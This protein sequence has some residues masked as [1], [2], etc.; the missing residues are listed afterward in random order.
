[1]DAGSEEGGV[2]VVGAILTAATR[3][4]LLFQSNKGLISYE[5]NNNIVINNNSCFGDWVSAVA[6]FI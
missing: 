3:Q 6:V 1:M 4:K 5:G 2:A